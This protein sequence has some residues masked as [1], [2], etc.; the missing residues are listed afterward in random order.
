VLVDG[1]VVCVVVTHR[2]VELLRR[3]L[4]S[5]AA[6]HRPPD[7]VVVVDNA[8]DAETRR[9][10]EGSPLPHTYL[11][12]RTNLGGAGGYAYGI[13]T[14]RALGADAVWLAD[15]DGRPGDPWTL[16]RLLTCAES[17]QLDAV[18]PAVVDE[19][20][21]GRLAFPLRQGLRWARRVDDLGRSA[22]VMG[23]ANLFNGALFSAA[24]LDAVGVPDPRLFIRGDEVELHRRMRRSGIRFATCVAATYEHPQGHDD[25]RPLWGGR[26]HV[27]VPQDPAKRELTY[28]NLGYLTAQPGLRWRAAP[29]ALRYTWFHLVTE[30]DPG[31][32]ARWWRSW[33]AGRHERFRPP[34]RTLPLGD[35]RTRLDHTGVAQR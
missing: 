18:S 2:R 13:L 20:D 14:A 25:W 5:V 7:H 23:A 31:A 34:R 27:L 11:P 19:T 10:V 32:L 29:D 21:P 6:Q 17:H 24:A 26:A 35:N 4:E 22:V 15:D 3:C 12:S 30:G 8:D 33:S 28:R 1:R 16:G 9:V